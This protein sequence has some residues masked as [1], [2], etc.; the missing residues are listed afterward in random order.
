[1]VVDAVQALCANGWLD[2]SPACRR[3]ALALAFETVDEGRGWYHFHHHHLHVSL[4]GQRSKAGGVARGQ[5]ACLQ[6]G[7]PGR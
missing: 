4:S 1:M 6:P 7:C 2:G 5:D 3:G